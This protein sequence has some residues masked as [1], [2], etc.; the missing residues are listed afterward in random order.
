MTRCDHHKA[1]S[2]VR[3]R[4]DLV[5]LKNLASTTGFFPIWIS[6]RNNVLY[7][8]FRL[9]SL[10]YRNRTYSLNPSIYPSICE[11]VTG[12]PTYNL[13]I[14]FIKDP[15]SL[16][17]SN[18]TELISKTPTALSFQRSV[19]KEREVLGP[20]PSQLSSR[21]F[22]PRNLSGSTCSKILSKIR[23]HVEIEAWNWIEGQRRA[24]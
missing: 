23:S 5:Q 16:R 7:E 20:K 3:H 18:I 10:F 21:E 11:T 17:R 2:I 12:K 1:R 24:S 4:R 19:G 14:Y 22:V 15:P 6:D 13:A 9:L 8:L